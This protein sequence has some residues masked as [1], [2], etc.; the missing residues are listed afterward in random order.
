MDKQEILRALTELE[1]EIAI[2]LMPVTV[3]N[4]YKG[5]MMEK[6]ALSEISAKFRGLRELLGEDMGI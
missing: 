4:E 6:Q 2:S 1:D 5:L 3:G